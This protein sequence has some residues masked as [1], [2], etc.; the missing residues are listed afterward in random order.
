MKQNE[1]I[2]AID[3]IFEA[4]EIVG[5][6]VNITVNI[7]P[8]SD[9]IKNRIYSLLKEDYDSETELF[10]HDATLASCEMIIGLQVTINRITAIQLFNLAI[11]Y[12]KEHFLQLNKIQNTSSSFY[13]INERYLS[14]DLQ[15]T[16]PT[17]LSGY[18]NYLLFISIFKTA[19]TR[20]LT[21]YEYIFRDENNYDKLV[22]IDKACILSDNIKKIDAAINRHTTNTIN[23]ID[24]L[25]YIISCNICFFSRKH[26]TSLASELCIHVEELIDGI[27]RDYHL[28]ISGFSFTKIKNTF[29]HDKSRYIEVI[30]KY[31]STIQNIV[32]SLPISIGLAILLQ[33][34]N[35]T[36]KLNSIILSFSFCFYSTISIIIISQ[37]NASVEITK[38][39]I[40]NEE[41]RLNEISSCNNTIEPDYEFSHFFN[42]FNKKIKLIKNLSRI[43]VVS[44]L[45]L[46]TIFLFKLLI[47]FPN[48]NAILLAFTKSPNQNFIIKLLRQLVSLFL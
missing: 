46:S 28:F 8:S 41:K 9:T 37:N 26:N 31:V 18:S 40:A 14:C 27:L 42:L 16:E 11:Y 4:S 45:L 47:M 10:S 35:S 13:I 25:L 48:I 33:L 23:Y 20:K 34:V 43:T 6:D 38:K 15:I 21:D 36:T 19:S 2:E 24:E 22:I 17:W 39:I 7:Y 30:D 5:F 1:Y 12:N 44:L 3:L 29:I 32:F